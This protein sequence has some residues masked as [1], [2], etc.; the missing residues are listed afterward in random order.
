[1][2]LDIIQLPEDIIPPTNIAPTVLILYSLPKV[3]KT[4]ILAQLPGNLIIDLEG[5]TEKIAAKKMKVVGIKAPFPQGETDE[6]ALFRRGTVNKDGT[7]KLPE[8]YLTEVIKALK[9]RGQ[10]YKYLTIDTISTLEDWC[11]EYGTELYM[12]STS[13]KTFNRYTRDDQNR[14]GGA[15]IEGTLKPKAQWETVIHLGHGYGYRWLYEAFSKILE[16]F[17]GCTEHLIL[18]GHLR[19]SVISKKTNEEVNSKDLALTGKLKQY[20]TGLV[21]DSIGYMHRRENKNFIN[22]RP[23]DEVFAG[24]RCAHI[25]GK[26]ILISEKLEDGTIKVYWENIYPDLAKLI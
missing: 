1:M 15:L 12:L 8:Y 16:A 10:K 26:D 7:P 20:A 3:G 13:G 17:A 9:A 14:S 24:S 18:T 4:N 2:A 25:E 22:F 21:A 23:S 6:Q 19:Y 11:V 5:G